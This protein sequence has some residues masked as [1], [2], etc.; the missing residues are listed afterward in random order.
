MSTAAPI[1]P[2]QQLALFDL[3]GTLTW[4]DTLVPFMAGYLRRHPAHCARWWRAPAAGLRYVVDRDRGKLKSRA[5]RMTMGGDVRT[6]VDAWAAEFVAALASRHML[7]PAALAVL[8]RHRAAGH[9]L[10]LLSA[11]P[12]LYVPHIGRLLGF[13]RTL[14]TEIKWNG[15]R[16]DGALATA[17]RH[18]AE[19]VAC[20][21]HLRAVYRGVRITAYGNSASDLPHMRLADHALLV[22]ANAATRRSAA[23]Q[24]IATDDWT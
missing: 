22:N 23:A 24:G 8:E 16:L 21:A 17:N 2:P 19:K 14:C 18:G 11:S 20:L 10:V 3:D 6:Q 13:E 5:I 7:R 12:D 4:Q 15:D 1:S 9:H